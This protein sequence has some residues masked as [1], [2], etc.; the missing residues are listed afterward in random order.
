[1]DSLKR[2]LNIA[3]ITVAILLAGIILLGLRQQQLGRDHNQI[4]AESEVILFQFSTLREEITSG[5][6]DG[7][8]KQ[9]ATSA[10]DIQEILQ[11]L[12]RLFENPLIPGEYKLAIAGK[13]DLSQLAVT[14][15]ALPEAPDKS[16]NGHI[17]QEQLRGIAEQL[18]QFDR[19]IVSQ[20]KTRVVDFQ[21]LY[22]TILGLIIA[23]ISLTLVTVYR[24]VILPLVILGEQADA[25]VHFTGPLPVPPKACREI[26]NFIELINT[27]LG[28]EPATDDKHFR[29]LLH[30]HD[31][32]HNTLIN[33]STNALNGIIN[34][35]QLL[36]DSFHG[37]ELTI[38]QQKLLDQ[39]IKNGERMA[40]LLKRP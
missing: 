8:W 5:L 31:E 32:H 10:D 34:V 38:D 23:L 6:I 27:R 12:N 16:Q 40:A 7:N 19:I 25:P 4:I 29:Q 24:R 9:V 17:L 20:L 22:I 37:Q 15:R 14:A 26:R 35:T 11:N 30:E 18:M 33:N 36:S 39:I 21:G 3:I 1:M 28:S 13:I 2:L